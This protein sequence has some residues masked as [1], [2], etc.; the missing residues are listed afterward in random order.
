MM[1]SDA[2]KR[3]SQKT[4]RR[5]SGLHPAQIQNIL[6]VCDLNVFAAI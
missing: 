1:A 4:N 5:G 3:Q 2:N 6:N